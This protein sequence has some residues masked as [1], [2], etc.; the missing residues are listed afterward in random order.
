MLRIVREKNALDSYQAGA[1][2]RRHSQVDSNRLTVWQRL[3]PERL[4]L[5]WL[6][7]C[8]Q[9]EAG[10][11]QLGDCPLL[12]FLNPRVEQRFG[13]RHFQIVREIDNVDDKRALDLIPLKTKIEVTERYGMGLNALDQ[14]SGSQEQ[15]SE[16]ADHRF[17]IS[18]RCRSH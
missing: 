2:I 18:A 4:R 5:N 17:A 10:L 3:D 14:A 1:S 9:N 15:Q 11:Y 8:N 12:R 6:A 13:R 7:I 16:S